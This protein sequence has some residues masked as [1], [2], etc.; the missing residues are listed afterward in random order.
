[1]PANSNYTFDQ[2]ITVDQ[3]IKMA[4]VEAK[5]KDHPLLQS[6]QQLVNVNQFIEKETRATMY[7]TLRANTGY[8]YQ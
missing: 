7:P 3:N 4:E 2:A 8:T 6:A 5:M 1:V